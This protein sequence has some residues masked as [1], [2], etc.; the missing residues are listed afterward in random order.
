MVDHIASLYRRP[1]RPLIRIGG[2]TFPHED[3]PEWF[4]RAYETTMECSVSNS[5]AF[6]AEHLEKAYGIPVKMWGSLED[7]SFVLLSR[8]PVRDPSATRENFAPFEEDSKD[9][10]VKRILSLEGFQDIIFSTW[11]MNDDEWG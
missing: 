1:E 2:Y 4:K 7:G 3:I 6:L 10:R 5:M 9:R 8:P 11:V